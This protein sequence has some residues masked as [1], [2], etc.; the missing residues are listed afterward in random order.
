ME[1]LERCSQPPFPR[2][3]AQ[4]QAPRSIVLWPQ[5]LAYGK[6]KKYYQKGRVERIEVRALYDKAWLK[7][8]LALPGYKS[9]NTSAVER[10]NGTSRLGNQRKV[11]KTLAFSKAPRYHSRKCGLRSASRR[12][13]TDGS[14]C[15]AM[16]GPRASRLPCRCASSGVTTPSNASSRWRRLTPGMT[17]PASRARASL[18][19]RRSSS[20]S[21]IAPCT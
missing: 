19:T 4:G 12:R 18:S 5:G 6:V 15:L 16:A 8:I 13:G 11:R 9:I 14:T 21:P 17:T 3:Q 2:R 7:H 1:S 20:T 10:H